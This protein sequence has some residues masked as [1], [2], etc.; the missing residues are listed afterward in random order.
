MADNGKK[1]PPLV[2]DKRYS[3]T[4]KTKK[5]PASKPAKKSSASARK[6]RKAPARKPQRKLPLI[7]ALPWAVITWAVRILFRLGLATAVI[8]GLILAAAIFYT[9]TT[10]PPLSQLV[11]GRAQQK[12]SASARS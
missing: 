4:S 8:A 2:A 11:D 1:R 12:C 9:S 6:T 10:I 3:S 7:L 5:K